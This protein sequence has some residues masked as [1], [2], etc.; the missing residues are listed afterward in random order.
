M[1]ISID[2][3]EKTLVLHDGAES[4]DL[5][6]YSKESFEVL[7]DLWSKVGWN[8]KY[9]YTFTWMGVP[10]IQLPEDIVRTQ[11]VLWSVKPDVIVECGVAHGGGAILYASL[12]KAMGKGRVIGVE[13]EFRGD[14]KDN[15]EKHLLHDYIDLVV[16]SSIDPT[17]VSQVRSKIKPNE[18][19]MVILDSN[20]SKA[21]VAAELEAYASMITVGSYIVATDGYM[22]DLTDV[23]RGKAEWKDDNPSSAALEFLAKH[24]EFRLEMPKPVFSESALTQC[25]THWPNAWLQKIS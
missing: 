11:E 10:I 7:S 22:K 23:P 6:L 4:R 5:S 18:T 13:L 19:V 25:I 20:H 3:S 21:H 17:I 15:I 14:H 9:T 16:G 12:C 1:K 2:T 24:P 8:E